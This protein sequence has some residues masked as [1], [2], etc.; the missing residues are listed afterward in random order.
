MNMTPGPE[1]RGQR[2]HA[3]RERCRQAALLVA[4]EVHV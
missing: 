3:R 1:E 2:L 4:R